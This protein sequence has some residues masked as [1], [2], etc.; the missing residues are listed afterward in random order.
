MVVE[1][2]FFVGWGQDLSPGGVMYLFLLNQ[3]PQ[4]DSLV[5]AK[6]FKKIQINKK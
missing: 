4:K 6:R 3:E 2:H 5:F 1:A